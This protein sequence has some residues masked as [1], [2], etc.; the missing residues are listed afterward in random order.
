[1]SREW[2]AQKKNLQIFSFS[3]FSFFI[4]CLSFYNTESF[5]PLLLDY[6]VTAPV[7]IYISLF[8]HLIVFQ[9]ISLLFV[10][11]C[12]SIYLTLILISYLSPII[13]FYPVLWLKKLIYN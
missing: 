13:F 7:F 9:V 2:L 10:C 5:V 8:Y 4:S 11:F 6:I 3:F 12:F 1:M